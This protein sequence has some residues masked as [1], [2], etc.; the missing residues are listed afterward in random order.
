MK[1]SIAFLFTNGPHNE[2]AG[3]EGLDALLA[4]SAICEN[5]GVFFVSDGIFLL[6]PD[7]KPEQIMAKNFI[8]AFGI[9]PL[10]NITSL[11]LCADSAIERGF[12]VH[13]SWLLNINFIPANFLNKTISLYNHIIKF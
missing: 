7:Q 11:Y 13:T 10:Y 12:N 5:I 3:R 6:L 9:I 2:A 4:I 8:N 1:K